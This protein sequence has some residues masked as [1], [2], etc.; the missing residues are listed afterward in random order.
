MKKNKLKSEKKKMKIYQYQAWIVPI[1]FIPNINELQTF[2]KNK[3][4]PGIQ[5]NKHKN[6]LM[7]SD[8][9]HPRLMITTIGG[10]MMATSS[11]KNNAH[12]LSLNSHAVSISPLI[13]TRLAV[14]VKITN[15]GILNNCKNQKKMI[16][17]L[18]E[19]NFCWNYAI[20]ATIHPAPP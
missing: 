13:G 10:K 4:L 1:F 11:N 12:P 20:I 17:I 16:S 6:R 9:P 8:D 14:A 7:K 5:S 3:R 15:A 19:S 18:F 2:P